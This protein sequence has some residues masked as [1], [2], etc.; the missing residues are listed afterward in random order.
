MR[1]KNSFTMRVTRGFVEIN[2]S[3]RGLRTRLKNV[4][5][6]R[7]QEVFVLSSEIIERQTSRKRARECSPKDRFHRFL[8]DF[9]YICTTLHSIDRTLS[10]KSLIRVIQ[11]RIDIHRVAINSFVNK[12]NSIARLN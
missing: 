10:Q 3:T 12:I 9:E 5:V 4:S 8:Y 7:I 6:F 11:V 2:V 1:D